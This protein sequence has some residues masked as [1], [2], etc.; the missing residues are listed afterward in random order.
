LI[1]DN[2]IKNIL[3]NTSIKSKLYINSFI[4]IVLLVYTTILFLLSYNLRYSIASIF[5]ISRQFLQFVIVIFVLENRYSGSADIAEID[6]I[7]KAI[8]LKF[9]YNFF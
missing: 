1:F 4:S 9:K 7:L 2:L 6:N 3:D 8:I 5:S